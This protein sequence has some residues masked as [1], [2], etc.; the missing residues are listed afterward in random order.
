ME[1][2][3]YF[4]RRNTCYD[5][6]HGLLL[7]QCYQCST[8]YR[9]RNIKDKFKDL[10][11]S[12][13]KLICIWISDEGNLYFQNL[14]DTPTSS[15]LRFPKLKIL[16]PYIPE[17]IA[18]DNFWNRK[19]DNT[20]DRNSHIGLTRLVITWNIGDKLYFNIEAALLEILK[21]YLFAILSANSTL[22]RI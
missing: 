6:Y 7:Q 14:P 18:S 19:R 11:D 17:P 9:T 3:W 22:P 16:L 1:I 15:G 21:S 13:S 12:C 2:F 4:L 8:S 10:T 20:S 5:V